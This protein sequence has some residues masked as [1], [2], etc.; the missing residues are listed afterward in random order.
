MPLIYQKLTTVFELFINSNITCLSSTFVQKIV[1]FSNVYNPRNVNGPLC[2]ENM[3]HSK[4]GRRP[5]LDPS[6]LTV[7]LFEVLS[8]TNAK[9]ISPSM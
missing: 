5:A 1:L 8:P 9:H 3:L 6:P 4:A 7:L 2:D